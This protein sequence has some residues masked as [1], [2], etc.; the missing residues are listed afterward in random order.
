[1]D[2][3][4]ADG[5]GRR[6]DLED[7]QGVQDFINSLD[8]DAIHHPSLAPGLWPW[9]PG[10]GK[11]AIAWTFD[12]VSAQDF[13]WLCY[14]LIA[15]RHD[16]F[17]RTRM[18]TGRPQHG[19]D[20]YAWERSPRGG[21]IACEAK[22]RASAQ[23]RSSG[24]GKFACRDINTA[25]DK[26]LKSEPAHWVR[27]FIIM[28]SAD[29]TERAD[30]TKQACTD[31]LR[32]R[33]IEL[34]IWSR[35]E[36]WQE[37]ARTPDVA[38]VLFGDDPRQFER[39]C[40]G[41]YIH[42]KRAKLALDEAAQAALPLSH[43][44]Q[45]HQPT[46]CR[47]ARDLTWTDGVV[48]LNAL[49]PDTEQLGSLVI[50]LNTPEHTGVTMT[51]SHQQILETLWPGH[52]TGRLWTHRRFAQVSESSTTIIL[53]PGAL[54]VTPQILE[55]FAAGVDALIPAYL[56][57]LRTLEMSWEAEGM[58][59]L[60]NEGRGAE[61]VLCSLPWWLWRDIVAFTRA[62]DV[63]DG[64]GPWFMFDPAESL[65]RPYHRRSTEDFDS[66]YHALLRVR[67]G[68]LGG[69]TKE[70][71]NVMLDL[72]WSARSTSFSPRNAWTAGHAAD[73]VMKRLIPEVFRWHRRKPPR[74]PLFTRFTDWLDGDV[75]ADDA[76]F[77]DHRREA[78]VGLVDHPSETELRRTIDRIQVNAYGLPRPEPFLI[79]PGDYRAVLDQMALIA[80]TAR[81]HH[82]HYAAS[83]LRL[84]ARAANDGQQFGKE[85][86][87]RSRTWGD[88]QVT[89]SDLDMMLRAL[90][91][92]VKDTR[93]VLSDHGRQDLAQTLRPIATHLDEM[94]LVDRHLPLLE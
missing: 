57:A 24:T 53:P 19:M 14:R 82:F 59:F 13:E 12:E 33:G 23:C 6:E 88:Q 21:M 27:R 89:G 37:L 79:S 42:L 70:P 25:V 92:I 28:T 18:L 50:M 68:D 34:E 62:H 9:Q 46:V 78:T 39:L 32:R 66:G 54:H 51:L 76:P 29:L 30:A 86:L 71:T 55:G 40:G 7:L 4:W 77:V 22:H 93:P 47:T 94:L 44:V 3:V 56:N 64:H 72:V 52:N 49:L 41:Y 8:H 26:F 85:L 74:R 17:G 43:T 87:D 69:G 16:I 67:A 2:D 11:L 84:S 58:R 38:A 10:G 15:A 90:V 31:K 1:M 73:W 61:V 91:S 63:D 35:A 48:T 81:T 5:P 20:F 60:H 65:L 80:A 83:K 75:D 36:L 45:P